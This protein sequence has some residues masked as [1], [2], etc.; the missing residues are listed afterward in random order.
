MSTQA[1]AHPDG[2]QPTQVSAIWRIPPL[3]ATINLLDRWARRGLLQRLSYTVVVGIAIIA[4]VALLTLYVTILP[5]GGSTAAV[6]D[7]IRDYNVVLKI[8]MFL[9]GLLF[10]TLIVISGSVSS[11]LYPVD[12]SP[13]KRLSW[14]G[15]ASDLA[16]IIYFAIE[17]GIFAANILLV[18]HVSDD[19]IHALHVVTFASAYLLGPLWIP[20]FVSLIVI[21][22]RANVFPTWMHWFAIYA[23]ITNALAWFGCFALTGPLNA[24]NGLVSLG[25][26]TIG[27]VPFI[28]AMAVYLVMEDLPAGLARLNAQL[29]AGDA[30]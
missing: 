17:V 27:P 25:G 8:A 20:F 24:M 28:A 16:L 10:L 19:I 14:I 23:C 30:R 22:R 4:V 11:K 29:K 9:A 6:V 18:G 2:V 3:A 15:F 1:L 13:G 12:V 26:P 21:S 5:D 7:F